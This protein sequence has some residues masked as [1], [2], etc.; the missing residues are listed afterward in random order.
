MTVATDKPTRR[1]VRTSDQEM[2]A[3]V[4]GDTLTLRPKGTRRGGPAEVSVLWGAI[5]YRAMLERTSQGKRR[6]R[7]RAR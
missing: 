3:E 7:R 2:V 1:I 5:Y 6:S 4:R